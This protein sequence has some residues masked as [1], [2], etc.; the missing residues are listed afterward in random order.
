MVSCGYQLSMPETAELPPY[1]LPA[2]GHAVAPSPTDA[3]VSKRFLIR[4][5]ATDFERSC[6]HPVYAS[7]PQ[8]AAST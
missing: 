7:G 4:R 6:G 3:V 1:S 8:D 2:L 5:T